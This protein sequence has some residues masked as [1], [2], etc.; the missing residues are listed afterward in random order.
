M[1]NTM[2]DGLKERIAK[3]IKVYQSVGIIVPMNNYTELFEAML[4][5]ILSTKED[6][7]V[8]ITITKSYD[9]INKKFDNLS[10]HNNIR[11][12]D[13]VSRASGISRVDKNCVYIESP[14]LLEKTILEMINIFRDVKD[15]IN[16]YMIID[17][18]SSLMI[19]NNPKIVKAFFQSLI[20]KTRAENIHTISLAIE[21]EL[22]EFINK[23]IFLNDK[24]IKVRESFI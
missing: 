17:S 23:I 9:T 16:K 11:F 20:N 3:S 13:C 19:Y 10:E 15:N 4:S 12:I 14:V 7:W 18:I 6:F 24:I 2:L 21:E 22:D 5:H 1:A 8:Y